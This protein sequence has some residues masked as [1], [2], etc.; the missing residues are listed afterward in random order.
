MRSG[1]YNVVLANVCDMADYA[2]GNIEVR[3]RDVVVSR[4]NAYAVL[5]PGSNT[6]NVNGR[7]VD[8]SASTRTIGGE[9]YAP[10]GTIADALGGNATYDPNRRGVRLDF[11][12]APGA[13]VGL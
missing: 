8:I 11:D 3:G 7:R 13:F 2:G 4:G 1:R 6:A 9:L 12:G 10:I 5:T